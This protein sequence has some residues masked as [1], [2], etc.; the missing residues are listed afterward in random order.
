MTTASVLLMQ[1]HLANAMITAKFI[2]HLAA[3][4]CQFA[5]LIYERACANRYKCV[6]KP[7]NRP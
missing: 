2:Y 6:S 1:H 4:M 7:K 5:N 3:Y